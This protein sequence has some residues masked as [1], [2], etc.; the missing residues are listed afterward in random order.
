M[1]ASAKK[2]LADALVLPDSDRAEL[3]A[4]LIESLD[5]E[6]EPGIVT[7]WDSEIQRRLGELDSGAV[8]SIPWSEAR[9]LIM[10]QSDG[11]AVD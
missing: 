11:A 10:G 3:A 4:E 5:R 1:N 8:A 9:K 7:N 6:F 2:V